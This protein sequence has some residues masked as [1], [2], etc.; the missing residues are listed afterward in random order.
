MN[1]L[2]DL[3]LKEYDD[4]LENLRR[5]EEIVSELL[6]RTLREGGILADDHDDGCVLYEKRALVERLLA[7]RAG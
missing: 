3:R 4:S 1:E 2:K 7:E 5:L 6:E